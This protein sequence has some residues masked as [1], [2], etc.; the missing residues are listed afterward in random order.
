M[1][2]I[3][4]VSILTIALSSCTWANN[5]G[6]KLPVQDE[7]KRCANSSFCMDRNQRNQVAV[8]NP[9]AANN[10]AAYPY[11]Q[12]FPSNAGAKTPD[13]SPQVEYLGNS[14]QQQYG[15]TPDAYDLSTKQ[16]ANTDYSPSY[17]AI[18]PNGPQGAGEAPQYPGQVP[19]YQQA[20]PQ[21]PYSLSPEEQ[22]DLKK[23]DGRKIY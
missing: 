15:G 12:E 21:S 1:K 5:L 22:E 14:P 13:G 6:K 9:E 4:T 7:S 10:P 8:P 23:K 20:V 11:Q 17:G 3:F 19:Q 2:N 18:A 16:P